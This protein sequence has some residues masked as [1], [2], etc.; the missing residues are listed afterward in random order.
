MTCDDARRH[1]NLYHDSEGDVA[2][3]LQ[4]G[5]HL[6]TCPGC[7]RWFHQESR[8]ESLIVEKLRA[9]P[10]TPEL[11]SRVLSGNG[12]APRPSSSRRWM[13]IV[14]VTACAASII[15]VAWLGS[16]W[17]S[18]D[19][20]GA[21]LTQL[22]AHWHERLVQG[23]EPVPFRS[24]SDLEVEAYLRRRVSF[25]VRCPPRRDAGFAVQGTGVCALAEQPSAFLVG[26]VGK[27]PVSIFVLPS[28]SLDAFPH[29]RDAIFREGTHHCR[30]GPYEMAVTVI[31]RNVVLVVG[32]A[33][34]DELL[35]ILKAYGSYPDHES[36]GPDALERNHSAGEDEPKAPFLAVAPVWNWW[37]FS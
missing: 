35:R 29:Q 20:Q 26:D 37:S 33:T 22:T 11:W 23:R 7:A 10:E 27:A 12:L 1:W 17:D 2:L 34:P 28:E 6:A 5:E 9:E 30:E 18:P 15:A 16:S 8:L 24:Q 4:I 19:A 32:Q 25:P 21:N 13:L 31:D 3:H 36:P 14:G